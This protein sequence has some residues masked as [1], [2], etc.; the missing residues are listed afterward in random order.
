[1]DL[2]FTEKHKLGFGL[3]CS[4]KRTLVN[5]RTPYQTL[6]VLDTCAFGNMLLLDGVVQTTVFDEFVYHEMIAHPAL[7]THPEPKRALVVGGGDGGTVREVLRHPSVESVEL[8][9]IDRRVVE[10]CTEHLKETSCGLTDPRVTVVYEDGIEYVK[11][12]KSTYDCIIVDSP[13]PVGPA[14][15]LFSADFYRSVFESLTEDGV[16]TA[17]TE[18]PFT[19]EG[20]IRRVTRDVAAVFPIG[21]FYI[22]N[23]PT[24]PAGMWGF[25]MGSKRYHPERDV[26]KSD[27]LSDCRYYTYELH[28]AMFAAVP[29]FARSLLPESFV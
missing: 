29:K 6:T 21:G 5:E 22:A 16:F 19:D 7:C 15:G 4:V 11:R 20:L 27:A 13:D 18:S 24:Y 28:K 9:E 3:T 23:I 14:T 2:W 25:T 17:Q 26:R 12:F 8:C 10:V 1:M